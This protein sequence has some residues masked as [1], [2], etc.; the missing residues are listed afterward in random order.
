MVDQQLRGLRLSRLIDDN[1][2]R[3]PRN[4]E[5][6]QDWVTLSERVH[7]W[8][9]ASIDPNL[10]VEITWRG[11]KTRWADEFMRQCRKHL[12]GDGFHALS[13]AI[14]KLFRT[15]RMDFDTIKEFIN[16]IESQYRV[17]NLLEGKLPPVYMMM[18]ITSELSEIPQLA[19]FID[20]KV[21]RMSTNKSMNDITIYDAYSMCQ[22][23]IEKLELFGLDS[24]AEASG[25]ARSQQQ[26]KQTFRRKSLRNA[27]PRGQSIKQHVEEWRNTPHQRSPNGK[28]TYCG[29]NNHGPRECRHLVS[30]NRFP[31]W[32]P[33]PG[34]WYYMSIQDFQNKCQGTSGLTKA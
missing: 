14:I 3:P 34:L 9:A 15:R 5:E 28:C 23:I 10:R 27:P 16:S 26:H 17:V 20:L 7:T 25:V 22:A 13:A 1:I 19:G 30:A 18:P 11:G 21:S 31:A 29:L 2:P 12:I 4:S 8:L 24:G 6:A 33:K 32:K